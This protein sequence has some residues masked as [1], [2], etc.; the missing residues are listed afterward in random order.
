MRRLNE[1]L[2]DQQKAL[3]ERARQ[4]AEWLKLLQS[5]DELQGT[6]W[7][8][9]KTWVTVDQARKWLIEKMN[10][11]VKPTKWIVNFARLL[12]FTNKRLRRLEIIVG[13]LEANAAET[14]E[15]FEALHESVGA[16]SGKSLRNQLAAVR[17]ELRS[18]QEKLAALQERL[19]PEA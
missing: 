10:G 11:P 9:S 4:D 3:N 13:D 5:G 8:K 17:G 1:D 18:F 19:D 2:A 12:L 14:R 15:V 16:I 6:D 7:L